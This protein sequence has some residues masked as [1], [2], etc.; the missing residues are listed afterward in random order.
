MHAFIRSRLRISYATL[1]DGRSAY[2]NRITNNSCLSH[3]HHLDHLD[4][5]HLRRSAPYFPPSRRQRHRCRPALA[6]PPPFFCIATCQ[7]CFA[8]PPLTYLRRPQPPILI[9]LYVNKQWGH[10]LIFI[11]P[12][13]PSCCSHPPH[14]HLETPVISNRN[15]SPL[16]S[17]P[18]QPITLP[19][20]PFPH[21]TTLTFR[22]FTFLQKCRFSHSSRFSPFFSSMP[23]HKSMPMAS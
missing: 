5:L 16:I 3:D 8:V 19:I 1:R 20:M 14:L 23:P 4:Q 18:S 15:F 12:S 21:S 6:I 13:F 17:P 10:C 9:A 2:P 7:L 11:S 22:S